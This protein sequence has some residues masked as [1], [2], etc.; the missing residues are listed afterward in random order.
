MARPERRQRGVFANANINQ[1]DLIA[2]LDAQEQKPFLRVAPIDETVEVFDPL[3][4]EP[5][6]APAPRK[7]EFDELPLVDL[8]DVGEIGEEGRGR[9]RRRTRVSRIIH[10]IRHNVRRRHK[11]NYRFAYELR[12]IETNEYT[13]WYKNLNSRQWFSKLSETQAWLQE[14]EDLRLQGEIIDRPSSKWVFQKHLFVD[15]KVILDR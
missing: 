6:V 7:R 5:E 10:K 9:R 2:W 1:Q 12:N 13:V 3:Y 4:N 8:Y 14:M 15:L 11:L